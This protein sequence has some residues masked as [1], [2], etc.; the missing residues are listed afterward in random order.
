[1]LVEN[2]DAGLPILAPIAAWVATGASVLGMAVWLRFPRGE[3][4]FSLVPWGAEML[5]AALAVA[6]VF[7]G[8]ASTAFGSGETGEILSALG[9]WALVTLAVALPGAGFSYL[10]SRLGRVWT[11]V[12]LGVAA[13]AALSAAGM[14]SP[15]I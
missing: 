13:A 7:W 4:W 9:R 8:P 11:F 15:S 10:L 1:V 12:A 2:T 5:V 6:T 14:M 3:V